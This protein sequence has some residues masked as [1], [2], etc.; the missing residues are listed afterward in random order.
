MISVRQ[1][2]HSQNDINEC[3]STNVASRKQM[4]LPEHMLLDAKLFINATI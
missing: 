2:I 3:C 1:L 4:W